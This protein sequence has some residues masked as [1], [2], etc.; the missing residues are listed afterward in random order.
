MLPFEPSPSA[1]TAPLEL[2]EASPGLQGFLYGFFILGIALALLMWSMTRHLRKLRYAADK[3]RAERAA[4]AEAAKKAAASHGASGEQSAAEEASSA[5][6][7]TPESPD[8]PSGD[9]EPPSSA[10]PA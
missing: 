5:T 7:A 4:R 6:E 3:E 2:W 8:D 10:S 1:D 9:T